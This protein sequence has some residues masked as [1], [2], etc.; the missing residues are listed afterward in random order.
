VLVFHVTSTHTDLETPLGALAGDLHAV[1]R[2]EACEAAE[3]RRT[4]RL[5]CHLVA[6]TRRAADADFLR[7]RGWHDV[8]RA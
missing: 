5:T 2:R 1:A 6:L 7:A 4:G 3:E 8:S